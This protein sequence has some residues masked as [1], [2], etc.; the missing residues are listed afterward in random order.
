MT[1]KMRNLLIKNIATLVCVMLAPLGIMSENVRIINSSNGL[2]SQSVL[3]LCQDSNGFI[4]AGTYTGLNLLNGFSCEPLGIGIGPFLTAGSIIDDIQK[5]EGSDI[6]VHTSL[7]LEKFDLPNGTFEYHPEISGTFRLATNN[8]GVVAVMKDDG[9]IHLYDKANSKFDY[10]GIDAQGYNRICNFFV[11]N[12]DYL[13]IA[14]ND[15][16]LYGK[17]SK[18]GNGRYT[19]KAL[20]KQ[21]KLMSSGVRGTWYKDDYVFVLDSKYNIYKSDITQNSQGNLLPSF[22]YNIAG[23]VKERGNVSKIIHDGKDIILGFQH[24]GAVRLKFQSMNTKVYA[25]EPLPVKGGVVDILKDRN[26]D[27]L[28]FAT[29]GMGIYL[30]NH[31]SYSLKNEILSRLSDKLISPV[32]SLY[33]D[34]QGN[35]WVGTKG[36]GILRYPAYQPFGSRVEPQYINSSNCQL[37]NN[38]VY[39]F[40]PSSMNILWI[41]SDGDA[42]NYYSYATQSIETLN[43]GGGK[44]YNVHDIVEVSPSEI[45]VATGGH[46]VF[47][48]SLDYRQGKPVARSAKQLFYDK[49]HPGNSQFTSICRQGDRYLWIGSRSK[50]V[51]RYDLKTGKTRIFSFGDANHNPK[52]DILSVKVLDNGHVF[53]ATSAGLIRLYDT[54]DPIK[55]EVVGGQHLHKGNV[56]FRSATSIGNSVWAVT[57]NAIIVYNDKTNCLTRLTADNGIKISE[58]SDGAAYYDPSTGIKYFG[59]TNGFVAVSRID[60][61]AQKDYHPPLYFQNISFGDSIMALPHEKCG[62]VKIAYRHND[63]VLSYNAPDYIDGSSYFFQYRFSDSEQWVDN[64]NHRQLSFTNLDYGTYKLKVRYIKGGYTSPEYCLVI[65]VLP[66]WYLSWWMKTLYLLFFLAVGGYIAYQ[67]L[68]RQQDKRQRL[69]NEM[70]QQRKNDVYTSKLRFFTNVTYEFS[71]PLSLIVGPCQRILGMN[72]LNEQVR[73]YVEIIQR[74]CQRLNKLISEI[75]EFQRIESSHRQ[76]NIL[77]VKVSDESLSL[78][79]MFQVMTESR[80]VRFTVNVQPNITWST[81]YD[82]FVNITTNM[83]SNAFKNV[84]EYGSVGMSLTVE[85]DCLVM[86]FSNT[87]PA[88]PK[89]KFAK[90]FDRYNILDRIEGGKGKD[91]TVLEFAISRGLILLLKGELGMDNHDGV[92][93]FTV[94]LPRLEVENNKN[95]DSAMSYMGEPHAI[96]ESELRYKPK[97][98]IVDDKPTIVL[99]D[100]NDEML[101]FINDCFEQ[102]YNV[103]SF[104][105]SQEALDEIVHYNPEV[106][107]SEIVL[108][109]FSGIEVCQRLKQNVVTAHIPIVLIST[110][111]NDKTRIAAMDADADAY[112]P[113]PCDI[114]YM[115]SVVNKF[116]KSN[117]TLK[118]YYESSLSSYEFVNAKFIHKEDKELFDKMMEII[119]DNLTNPEL[120]TQFIAAKLGLGVRNLYRRLQNITDK[121]PSAF[122]KDMRLEKARQLLTK[123]KMSM[124]EVCYNSGFVNRGTFYKLF[125]AKFNCTPKQYHDMM[126][127]KT[128]EMLSDYSDED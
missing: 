85:D 93:V 28:W 71:V 94:K 12:Y 87:G 48:I 81:D 36:N 18:D 116:M 39:S 106:I 75:L 98:K 50:G 91:E 1:L 45:W 13:H 8:N 90:M 95:A 59:G 56:V 122:I 99:I 119:K 100:D 66:P 40:A 79:D 115:R 84:H 107:M 103:V 15:F 42:L 62:K 6:W 34:K 89:E 23:L 83:L 110:V 14:Y 113:L 128:E 111:N 5:G 33:R 21:K 125:A 127:G 32:R 118:N 73:H 74:N 104:R 101:W 68:A 43:V 67:Y 25:E 70:N 17:I 77:N 46:G 109:P 97:N 31:E 7:G 82:A 2:S 117:K 76:V 10:T 121:K 38:S 78:V 29:D 112:I 80:H 124:E 30:L 92:N 126:I 47:R 63:F 3:R 49:T 96:V 114:N 120:S 44:M 60:P 65:R 22:V 4:L 102:D 20:R 69:V 37:V 57:S 105:D 58:F 53:C 24:Q 19:L 11:D 35:L 9:K 123:S 86:T 51:Y 54:N 16:H 27:I 88:I 52:N 61:N 55:W 41:G 26:Q 108:Q 64:G 72:G